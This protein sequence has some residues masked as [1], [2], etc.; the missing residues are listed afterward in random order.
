MSYTIIYQ[1]HVIKDHI[2]SL[3]T[4]AKSM[5]KKSIE[6]RLTADPIGLG[7]PLRYA[8]RGHRSLRVS[9]YRVIYKIEKDVVTVVAIKH[10]KNAYL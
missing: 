5:I 8:L 9:N 6:D 1:D 2:P 3:G 7:K 10:R 4:K